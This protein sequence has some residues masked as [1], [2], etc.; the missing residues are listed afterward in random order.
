[1]DVTNTA[2]RKCLGTGFLRHFSHVDGGKCWDCTDTADTSYTHRVE[3]LS[4]EETM[5]RFHEA[6]QLRSAARR[7]RRA[8]GA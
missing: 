1:M 4:P 8:Q 5:A 6:N 3:V 2:C 7:E